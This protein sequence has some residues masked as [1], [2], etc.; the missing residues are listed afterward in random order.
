MIFPTEV[1]SLFA[2]RQSQGVAQLTGT[3]LSN[4]LEWAGRKISHQVF[5]T[6]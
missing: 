2:E 4:F 3:E 1:I 6:N 5:P